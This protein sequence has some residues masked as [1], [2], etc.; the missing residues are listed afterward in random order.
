MFRPSE[1]LPPTFCPYCWAV[2]SATHALPV[3][4]PKSYSNSPRTI[5]GQ[6]VQRPTDVLPPNAWHSSPSS[7]PHQLALITECI[8]GSLTV[9]CVQVPNPQMGEHGGGGE[10]EISQF[11][12]PLRAFVLPSLKGDGVRGLEG[13]P[14][15]ARSPSVRSGG[16]GFQENK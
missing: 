8:H 16:S 6:L 13:P 1:F 2:L 10:V 4:D 7:E 15:L 14:S 3:P 9:S 5:R 11:S 12:A